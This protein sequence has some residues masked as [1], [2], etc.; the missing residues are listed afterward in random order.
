MHRT[1]H[2]LSM[3]KL[4]HKVLT[5]EAA[6]YRPKVHSY[7]DLQ[8]ATFTMYDAVPSSS[9]LA[10]LASPTSATP[11]RTDVDHEVAKFLP[12]LQDYL[13]SMSLA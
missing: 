12:L 2:Y 6:G 5:L 9:S 8:R 11:A 1:S 13:K 4:L 3:K 10:S 7:K